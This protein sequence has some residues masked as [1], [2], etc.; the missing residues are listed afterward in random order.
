MTIVITAAEV[1]SSLDA[2]HPVGVVRRVGGGGYRFVGYD[3]TVP[4]DEAGEI[5]TVFN[6]DD[7]AKAYAA[8]CDLAAGFVKQVE[9]NPVPF[10]TTVAHRRDLDAKAAEL[11][12][13]D[14]AIAARDAE[15]ADLRRK[16]MIAQSELTK[17]PARRSAARVAAVTGG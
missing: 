3:G 8:A 12:A 5:I 9:A 17:P 10:T 11:A 16:L 4:V 2:E 7:D 1:Y 13:R 14:E 6:P 15:L